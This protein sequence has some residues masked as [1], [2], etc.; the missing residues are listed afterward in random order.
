MSPSE[1]HDTPEEARRDERQGFLD[2]GLPG[3]PTVPV[4]KKAATAAG[5]GTGKKAA[6]SHAAPAEVDPVPSLLP[7]QSADVAPSPATAA[8]AETSTPAASLGI[9]QAEATVDIAA[10]EPVVDVE[11]VVAVEPIVATASPVASATAM[12]VAA[13]ATVIE[14]NPAMSDIHDTRDNSDVADLPAVP[15]SERRVALPPDQP[16]P[17][18]HKWP[19]RVRSAQP[20]RNTLHDA[21]QPSASRAPLPAPG[22]TEPS[23]PATLRADAQTHADAVIPS[24]LKPGDKPD[25]EPAIEPAMKPSIPSDVAS[26]VASNIA[27]A[28]AAPM[29]ALESTGKKARKPAETASQAYPAE[30]LAADATPPAG[31]GVPASARHTRRR[32]RGGAG[33]LDTPMHAALAPATPATATPASATLDLVPA[34]EAGAPASEASLSHESALPAAMPIEPEIAAGPAQTAR[35]YGIDGFAAGVERKPKMPVLS[36][37]SQVLKAAAVLQ[38]LATVRRRMMF[39]AGSGSA[40]PLPAASSASSAGL[41]GTHLGDAAATVEDPTPF[42]A[43][44]PARD[45]TPVAMDNRTVKFAAWMLGLTAGFGCVTMVCA[46]WGLSLL[47][48]GTASSAPAASPASPAP[49]AAAAILASPAPMASEPMTASASAGPETA[50]AAAAPAAEHHHH[51]KPKPKP[52]AKAKTKTKLAA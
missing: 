23:L 46:I 37:A 40:A 38:A 5:S 51:H 12:P 29:A 27:P 44:L 41:D 14:A 10:A 17:A 47:L 28:S 18:P 48:H 35:F 36:R 15:R 26:D 9:M 6:A 22:M 45:A 34:P 4:A 1:Q 19:A 20:V 2:L 33:A 21:P 16:L 7:L 43:V 24:F 32:S 42:V 39:R 13:P 25:S 30:A 3:A 49:A 50:S 8:P 31:T 11:P 52:K